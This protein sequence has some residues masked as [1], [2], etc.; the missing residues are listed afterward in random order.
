MAKRKKPKQRTREAGLGDALEV[1]K[2]PRLIYRCLE[3]GNEG[4]PRDMLIDV[5]VGDHTMPNGRVVPGKVIVKAP[6]C[7]FCYEQ[8]MENDGSE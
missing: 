8:R 5:M 2:R 3:C 7:R 6:S 1:A 4:H